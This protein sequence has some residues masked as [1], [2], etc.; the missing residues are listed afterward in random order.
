MG[1]FKS[2]N[3][4]YSIIITTFAD[5]GLAKKIAKL[6]IEQKLVACVQ[7]FPIESVYLWKNEICEDSE[8]A[9]LVKSKT[10]LFDKITTVI[11]GAH[12]YEVPEIIQI[13]I[14]DGLPEYLSWIDDCT[15]GAGSFE[16][17]RA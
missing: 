14:T 15:K 3:S 9:V 11:K 2:V 10:S 7:M 4:G 5:R 1:G 6:L 17:D 13:P 12:P 16:G 8:I